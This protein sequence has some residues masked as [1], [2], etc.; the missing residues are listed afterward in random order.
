MLHIGEGGV[1]GVVVLKFTFE[2]S[3]SCLV[4]SGLLDQDVTFLVARFLS[5]LV[6]PITTALVLN[7]LKQTACLQT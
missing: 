6:F 3:L 2:T 7:F 5:L 4:E 1:W